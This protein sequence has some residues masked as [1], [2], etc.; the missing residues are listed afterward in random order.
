MTATEILLA[1]RLL[2]TCQLRG[3]RAQ[4]NEVQRLTAENVRLK[5]ND[6]NTGL[7]E[8]VE[9]AAEWHLDKL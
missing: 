6:E 8:K 1:A 4:L 5:V 2:K 9:A 7:V 3:Q